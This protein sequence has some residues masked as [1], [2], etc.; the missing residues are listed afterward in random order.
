[1]FRWRERIEPDGTLYGVDWVITDR[2]GGSSQ[3]DFAELNLAAHVGDDPAAVETNRHRLAHGFDV[4]L[5]DLRFMDQQHGCAVARVGG[6]QVEP[7]ESPPPPPSADGL[8]T[9]DPDV[10]LVVLVADCTPVM[11]VDRTEG[12]AAVVHAGRPGMTSGVVPA[13]LERLQAMGARDLQA[14]VGPSICGR[15]YEVPWQMR[16]EVAAVSPVS[17][18]LSWTGTPAIDVAAGVVDQLTAACVP[19]Q[20]LPGCSRESADLYSYRRDGQTGRYAAA[21]RLLAAESV[22]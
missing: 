11:L 6:E 21:V 15:C 4:A 1:V 3:G 22:A 10:V 8:I 9:D 14:V 16:D 18:T 12:L 7:G 13:T 19:M 2:W 17:A 5:R 20:W